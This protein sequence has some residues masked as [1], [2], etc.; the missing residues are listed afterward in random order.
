[1]TQKENLRALLL[2]ALFFLAVGG[3]LLHCRIHVWGTSPSNFIPAVSGIISVGLIPLLFYFRS[4]VTFGYLLDGITVIIGMITMVH[5]TL[6]NAPSEWSLQTIFFQTLMAD[7]I[8]LCAKFATGKALFDLE[9]V[10]KLD[11]ATHGGRFFR[12]PNMGFWCVHLVAMSVV[13]ILGFQ[14]WK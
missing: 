10:R 13:Y 12:Y 7:I 8:M 1:M 5:F 3:L 14:V 2:S 11:D 6:K 4:T 9:I